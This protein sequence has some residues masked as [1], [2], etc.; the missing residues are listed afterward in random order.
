MSKFL[1]RVSLTQDGAKGLATP[2]RM[3][4]RE[5]LTTLL[6]DSDVSANGITMMRKKVNRLRQ[7]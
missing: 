4:V 3:G 1:M 6:N 2:C 5:D 7:I